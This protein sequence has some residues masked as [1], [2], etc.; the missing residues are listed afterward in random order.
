[1]NTKTMYF[2][3]VFNLEELKKQY[4][5]LAFENHPDRG[6][7]EEVMKIINNEY[8]QLFNELKSN[9]ELKSNYRSLIDGLLNIENIDIEIIGTWVWV[10]GD[11][12][13]VKEL[14]DDLGFNWARKK[15][16]WYWH[17]GQYRKKH[18]KEYTLEEIR[19]MHESK[20]VKKG[21]KTDERKRKK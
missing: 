10:T 12:R 4:K 15:K 21:S 13:P 9:E 6:G 17:E 18:K 20:T 16:A 7:N 1:M 8:D 19:R 5:K 11:T 14:L 2:K 3:N